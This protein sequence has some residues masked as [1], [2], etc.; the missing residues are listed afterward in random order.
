[1]VF[2][3]LLCDIYSKFIQQMTYSCKSPSWQLFHSVLGFSLVQCACISSLIPRPFERRRKGLVHTASTCTGVSIVTG[4]IT[5]VTFMHFAWCA[6]LWTINGEHT[7]VSNYPTFFWGPRKKCTQCVPCRPFLL[8]LK[9][10]GTRLM[11]V[12]LFIG[13]HY[14]LVG[15]WLCTSQ[16][17]TSN[18]R[19]ILCLC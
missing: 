10:L 17:L 13:H 4:C 19:K 11:F 9:G 15:V 2:T 5:V 1:M 12:L 8:L 14:F 18:A 16:W 6:F 7:V 3:R